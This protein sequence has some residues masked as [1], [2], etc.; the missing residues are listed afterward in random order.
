MNSRFIVI[1]LFMCFSLCYVIYSFPCDYLGKNIAVHVNRGIGA[2]WLAILIEYEDGD[3]NIQAVY[4]NQVCYY[5]F[6]FNCTFVYQSIIATRFMFEFSRAG[7]HAACMQYLIHSKECNK[8]AI[9]I[10]I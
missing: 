9:Q 10:C 2:Y 3:D 4:L 6:Q 1:L 8:H 5:T 7:L